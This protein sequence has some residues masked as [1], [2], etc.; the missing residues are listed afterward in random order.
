MLWM[1]CHLRTL[2]ACLGAA[3][4]AALLAVTAA[5]LV[6]GACGAASPTATPT[7][8]VSAPVDPRDLTAGIQRIVTAA[9][10]TPTDGRLP[11]LGQ[12]A[13][14]QGAAEMQ[15]YMRTYSTTPRDRFSF[16]S[17][18]ND[19]GQV[20]VFMQAM[21]AGL[22]VSCQYCHDFTPRC[23]N[24]WRFGDLDTP[25]MV[26]AQRMLALVRESNMRLR[27]MPG[28]TGSF[29]TCATCH[30]GRP[31]PPGVTAAAGPSVAGPLRDGQGGLILDDAAL[32]ADRARFCRTLLA[33]IVRR[34]DQ[35]GALPDYATGQRRTP[36]CATCHLGYA[37]PPTVIPQADLEADAG[38]G[39]ALLPPILRGT[40]Q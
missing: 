38:H 26:A 22:G 13:W 32:L 40:D 34:W 2:A 16:T 24:D 35:Y 7:P 3:G 20:W 10:N 25:Q 33:D 19:L 18:L 15:A 31:T 11:W 29:I 36:A 27:T 21:S 23:A 12:A 39:G 9:P 17:T 37:I 14:E 28:W 6:L 4:G 8:L 5:S 30:Q 1:V